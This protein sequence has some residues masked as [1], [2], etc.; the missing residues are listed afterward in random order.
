MHTLV[1]H[2]N[3]NRAAKTLVGRMRLVASTKR[4][5]LLETVEKLKIASRHA[6]SCNRSFKF[7]NIVEV[8]KA[9]NAQYNRTIEDTRQA[10]HAVG[11]LKLQNGKPTY[12]KQR[13]TQRE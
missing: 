9:S 4:S 8:V 7:I 2:V 3:R 13:T 10:T 11:K 5:S 12:R 6:R 1:N